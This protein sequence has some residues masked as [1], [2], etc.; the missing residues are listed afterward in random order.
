[1]DP[2]AVECCCCGWGMKHLLFF[3]N[4]VV[5]AGDITQVVSERLVH[6]PPHGQKDLLASWFLDLLRKTFFLPGEAAEMTI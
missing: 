3:E 6:Q 4:G 1:M 2:A 5:G